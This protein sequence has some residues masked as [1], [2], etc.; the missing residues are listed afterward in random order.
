MG[1]ASQGQCPQR[2]R[3]GKLNKGKGTRVSVWVRHS[4]LAGM[5]WLFSAGL[6]LAWVER[7]PLSAPSFAW[8]WDKHREHWPWILAIATST[9]IEA[10]LSVLV[11]TRIGLGKFTNGKPAGW[12][13]QE[14]PSRVLSRS[15]PRA[16][17]DGRP[18]RR[19][20]RDWPDLLAQSLIIGVE[21]MTA[22]R[23]PLPMA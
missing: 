14:P 18:Q 12:F 7:I 13:G 21:V 6:R 16:V 17:R 8:T 11:Q 10:C 23:W 20:G 9:G 19:R 2:G 15:T 1:V 4:L 22:S 5:H 3:S